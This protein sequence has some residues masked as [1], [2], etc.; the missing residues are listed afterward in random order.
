MDKRT[1]VKNSNIG[2]YGYPGLDTGRK[3]EPVTGLA[4]IRTRKIGRC[5]VPSH[6]MSSIESRNGVGARG[7]RLPRPLGARENVA[8]DYG[9]AAVVV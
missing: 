1:S 3:L 9:S 6:P 5:P 4:V 8:S 7:E 2:C